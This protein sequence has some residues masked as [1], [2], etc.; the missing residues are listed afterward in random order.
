MFLYFI[1][2]SGRQ[3]SELEDCQTE[4]A[5]VPDPDRPVNVLTDWLIS[6]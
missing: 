2:A 6:Y 1:L 3:Q 4:A 5:K